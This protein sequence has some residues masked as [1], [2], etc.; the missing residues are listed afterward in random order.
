MAS[1]SYI[2]GV[3]GTMAQASVAE[4]L[5]ISKIWFCCDLG[6]EL[7]M[8]IGIIHEKDTEILEVGL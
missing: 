4:P 3:S 2:N 8:V 7:H 1:N 6:L 5:W